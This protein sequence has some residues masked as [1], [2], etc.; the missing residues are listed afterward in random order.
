[1]DD[2]LHRGAPLA[3]LSDFI[4]SFWLYQSGP[5][6]HARERLLPTGIA[7][8]VIDLRGDGLIAPDS[9]PDPRPYGVSAGD[10]RVEPRRAAHSVLHGPYTRPIL[11]GT[12]RPVWR[13]GVNFAPAGM[14]RFF[15]L[16]ASDLQNA[17]VP[18]DALWGTRVAEELGE[19]LAQ[20]RRPAEQFGVL[21][22]M[23][24]RQL[25]RFPEPHPAVGHAV[26]AF[27]TT[28]LGGSLD[29]RL[30]IASVAEEAGL[31]M[32]RLTRLF[33]D[34]VG[35]S[36]KRYIRIQ[37][38]LRVLR[39]TRKGQPAQWA[40]LAVECG[41]YDQA[42]LINEFHALAGVSPRVYLR[43]R[44]ERSPTDLIVVA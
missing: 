25:M 6:P 8:L 4:T 19:R 37:R 18:L 41:Y 24:A 36:P 39:R 29:H 21:E 38:F 40:R 16:P 42:H 26:R 28:P 10:A 44:S 22:R 5:L 12:D 1:M 11:L 30:R 3:P 31:S 43:D 13:L 15:R 2:M 23:L 9:F 17:D 20:A 32:G 35:L 14:S 7:Q 33:K 34:A 27:S